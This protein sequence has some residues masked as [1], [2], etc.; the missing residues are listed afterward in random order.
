MP[1]RNRV[2]NRGEPEGALPE[3]QITEAL[4]TAPEGV[5]DE[6]FSIFAGF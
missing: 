2:R 4:I 6:R 1:S 5:G 3:R